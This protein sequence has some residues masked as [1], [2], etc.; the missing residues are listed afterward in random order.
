MKLHQEF[1]PQTK[2]FVAF[3]YGPIVLAGRLGREG[4]TDQQFLAQRIPEKSAPLLSKTPSWVTDNP[5]SVLAH[6]TPVAGKPLTFRATGLTGP[7]E[8]E[9]IP[10]YRLHEERYNVYWRC[11]TPAALERERRETAEQER[12]EQALAARTVD[13]VCPGDAE[14]EAQHAWKGERTAAGTFHGRRWRH[15]ADGWFSYDLK[16]VSDWPQDLLCTYWGSDGGRRS[17]DI[18]VEGEKIA[19]QKLERN[20]PGE[21][22]DVTYRIPR[23]LTQGKQKITVRFQAHPKAT[24]GGVF[25]VRVLKHE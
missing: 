21:F 9:L 5:G 10:F 11:V 16:V 3:L 19:T 22:F 25:D 15:A 13:S 6:V 8:V 18:L 14:S 24:A 17:F 20:K 12:R 23:T 4:M 1:L 7:S 2:E